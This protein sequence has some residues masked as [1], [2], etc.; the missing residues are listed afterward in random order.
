MSAG[1]N[2]RTGPRDALAGLG[3]YGIAVDDEA[4]VVRSRAA[5]RI[6]TADSEVAV[7]VGPT[8][9]GTALPRNAAAPK[10]GGSRQCSR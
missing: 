5:R 2:G 8:N 7:R 4:N 10:G 6:S 3:R 9:T 1:G